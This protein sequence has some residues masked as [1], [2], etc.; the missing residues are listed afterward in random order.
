MKQVTEVPPKLFRAECKFL[1]VQSDY[2]SHCEG[3][4]TKKGT[5]ADKSALV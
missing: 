2:N 4:R 5:V 3:N 1:D